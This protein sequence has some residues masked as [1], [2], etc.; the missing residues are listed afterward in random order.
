VPPDTELAPA[1]VN[2]ALHVTGRRDDGYHLLDSLVVFPR[3]CDR[4]EAEPAPGLSLSID[5]TFARDLD[6]GGSNLVLRAAQLMRSPSRGA[7]LRLTKSLP[8]A[9]GI[10]G[11]SAD[12]A[13]T[14]RLLAR[15][16]DLPLP[17]PAALLGLG[18]DLPVCVGGGAARLRGIGDRLAPVALPRFWLVLVNPGTPVPT[19]AVFAGL[20]RRENPPMDD[21]ADLGTL[22]ALVGFL[23]RQ[24]NDLEAPALAVAPAIGAVLAALRAQRGCGVA[25]MSG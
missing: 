22:P 23:A 18:A 10:G 11:G 25:R 7:A 16:W 2:L 19:G 8:V 6:A 13:A 9:S 14:L 12:A 20:Q 3:I 17:G 5:G 24:R 1:K 4:L 15:L 21:P